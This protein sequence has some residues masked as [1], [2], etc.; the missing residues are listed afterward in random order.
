VDITAFR[1]KY[2]EFASASEDTFV[3]VFLNAAAVRLNAAYWGDY[4]DQAH[5]LL[6]AHLLAIAPNGQ[7]ARLQSKDGNTTYN[8]DFEKLRSEVTFADR[9]F[10]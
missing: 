2:P 5:G 10:F 8:T 7:F 3:Q 9:V 6:T 4:Y 1:V